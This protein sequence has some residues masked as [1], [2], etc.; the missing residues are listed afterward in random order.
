MKEDWMNT[1][2]SEQLFHYLFDYFTFRICLLLD[3]L[4]N[5]N[6]KMAETWIFLCFFGHFQNTWYVVSIRFNDLYSAL[7]RIA[8]HHDA[9]FPVIDVATINYSASFVNCRKCPEYSGCSFILYITIDSILM[10]RWY[11]HDI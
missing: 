6:K 2:I 7:S 1:G 8:L 11:T 10:E 4:S 3:L 9:T 5:G